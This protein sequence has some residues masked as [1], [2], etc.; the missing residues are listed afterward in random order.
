SALRLA[1]AAATALPLVGGAPASYAGAVRP[2]PDRSLPWLRGLLGG[3]RGG[4]GRDQR[5]L[6]A[7][8][9]TRSL[10]PRREDPRPRAAAGGRG[11][12]R[13]HAGRRAAA[14]LAGSPRDGGGAVRA[15]FGR[16]AEPAP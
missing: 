3:T 12:G 8:T 13:D 4:A 5:H 11:P 9:G 14:R 1:R 15:R 7:R 10:R 2:G 6:E 16:A